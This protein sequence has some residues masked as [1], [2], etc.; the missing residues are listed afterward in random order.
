MKFLIGTFAF[1][2]Y[3]LNYNGRITTEGKRLAHYDPLINYPL[4]KRSEQKFNQKP[5]LKASILER[6][7]QQFIKFAMIS[8]VDSKNTVSKLDC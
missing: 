2:Q 8:I 6:P 5:C 7:N 1:L 4:S 3:F